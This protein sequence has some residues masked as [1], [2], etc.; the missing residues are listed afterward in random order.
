MKPREWWIR[1]EASFNGE[2]IAESKYEIGFAGDEVHVREILSGTV[3]ITRAELD[4]AWEK[5]RSAVH[6]DGYYVN[7]DAL[8]N[9][10]AS[11]VE[12]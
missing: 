9:E 12:K 4:R 1:P 11:T 8:W 5:A 2:F 10:L 7:S 3:T 6:D